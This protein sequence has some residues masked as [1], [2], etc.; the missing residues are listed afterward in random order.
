MSKNDHPVYRELVQGTLD[1][2]SLYTNDE[3]IGKLYAQMSKT[4]RN[5]YIY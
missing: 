3:I 1:S 4:C 2:Q 5:E